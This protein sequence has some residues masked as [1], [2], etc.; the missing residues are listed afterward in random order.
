MSHTPFEVGE[1]ALVAN[2]PE[3]EPLVRRWRQHEIGI[4]AHV[5]I[6]GPFLHVSRI[7]ED[8]RRDLRHLFSRHAAIEASFARIGHF[9]GVI[10]LAPEPA[11]AFVELTQAVVER[12]PETPPY[13]GKFEKIVP[14]LS[15]AHGAPAD[16][17]EISA[18]LPLATHI[19]TVS[20]IVCDDGECWSEVATYSLSAQA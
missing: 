13:G 20:L 2:V 15:V 12:W 3:A 4:M 5:T 6:L 19:D 9:P 7:D 17:A 8:V 11:S 10:Y 18:A 14:H 16:E 1:T